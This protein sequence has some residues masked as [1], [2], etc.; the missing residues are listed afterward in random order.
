MN[1]NLARY[2]AALPLLA[3]VACSTPADV[4]AEHERALNGYEDTIRKALE[5][6]QTENR[7]MRRR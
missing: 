3:L 6:M 4:T 2:L 1:R 7:W 5:D